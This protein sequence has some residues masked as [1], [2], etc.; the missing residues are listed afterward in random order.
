L[1]RSF[2]L[3]LLRRLSFFSKAENLKRH[4]FAQ[5]DRIL[6]HVEELRSDPRLDAALAQV[7]VLRKAAHSSLESEALLLEA[8]QRL[9]GTLDALRHEN[10]TQ[11]RALAQD[12]RAEFDSILQSHAV[13]RET[14]S[15][16]RRLLAEELGM[17]RQSQVALRDSHSE[18][19]QTLTGVS[20]WNGPRIIKTSDYSLLNPEAALLEH[21]YA[22]LP[23]R[24]AVDVGAHVGEIAARLLRAGYEV[25]AFEPSPSVFDKLLERL[26]GVAAFHPAAFAIGSA[27]QQMDLHLV[28]DRTDGKTYGDVTQLSSLVRHALPDGLTLA[29]SVRVQVRSLDSLWRS[30]ELPKDVALVKIDAEGYDVEVIRGMGDHHP[31]VIVTEFWDAEHAFGRSYALNR[32]EH[33]VSELRRRGYLWHI[34]LYRTDGSSEVSYFANHTTS[35][36]Q[37][38]GNCVFFEDHQVFVEALRWCG[39]V[40]RPTYFVG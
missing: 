5:Q 21:L 39:A 17:I 29:G 11:N 9:V 40:L 6:G 2:T 14:L 35:V 34:V 27:D 1:S 12:L 33:L 18:L 31:A 26:G 19:K 10:D 16:V 4:H 13:Q 28:M 15:G 22:H 3:Q 25:Y 32:L 36:R 37:S 23:G 38:W 24:V 8:C 20:E 30:G 7:E